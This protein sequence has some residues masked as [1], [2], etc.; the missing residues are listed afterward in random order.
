MRPYTDGPIGP[1]SYRHSSGVG[2]AKLIIFIQGG[3]ANYKYYYSSVSS[4]VTG[5]KRALAKFESVE[6]ADDKKQPVDELL[7]ICCSRY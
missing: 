5:M 1:L 2:M 3:N 7:T 6:E 4:V